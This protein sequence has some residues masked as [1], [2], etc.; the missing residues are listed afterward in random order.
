MATS[1]LLV[2]CPFDLHQRAHFEPH[3]QPLWDR[4]CHPTTQPVSSPALSSYCPNYSTMNA[5]FLP[6]MNHSHPSRSHHPYHS[7]YHPAMPP[8]QSPI[9]PLDV[10][11]VPHQPNYFYAQP[12]PPPQPYYSYA[13]PAYLYQQLN[14]LLSLASELRARIASEVAPVGAPRQSS[15]LVTMDDGH[16]RANAQ[17]TA[18]QHLAPHHQPPRI[19]LPPNKITNPSS[20]CLRPREL[21]LNQAPNDDLTAQT[22]VPQRTLG[23][24]DA[25]RSLA[26]PVT[27]ASSTEFSER[28]TLINSDGSGACKSTTASTASTGSTSE[29]TFGSSTAGLSYRAMP[30]ASPLK[31]SLD[32]I[33]SNLA[34]LSNQ[35][36]ESRNDLDP[37]VSTRFQHDV[38]LNFDIIFRN[39]V[40]RAN[41]ITRRPYYTSYEE[42]R[43]N[44]LLLIIENKVRASSSVLAS[45]ASRRQPVACGSPVALSDRTTSPSSIP[46]HGMAP[47]R[48]QYEPVA[49]YLQGKA[50]NASVPKSYDLEISEDGGGCKHAALL[51]FSK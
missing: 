41:K 27:I 36:Q 51:C 16:L 48:S 12:A 33:R 5:A 39:A 24:M 19:D 9:A 38:L 26:S 50:S 37:A 34:A 21:E 30:P 43:L 29:Y 31:Q 44:S 49:N 42:R 6:P 2:H 22:K 3:E 14:E 40:A 18:P 17:F 45:L 28:D 32:S 15:P 23:H 8:H 13:Q 46:A 35:F 47:S 25:A 4:P 10:A 7:N 1:S 20:Q 11:F